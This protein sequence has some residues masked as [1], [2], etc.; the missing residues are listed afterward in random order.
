M[1]TDR[2][3]RNVAQAGGGW[4]T[5]RKYLSAYAAKHGAIALKL[6]GWEIDEAVYPTR[7]HR[8]VAVKKKGA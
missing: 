7:D 1:R 6:H 5:R 8:I 4:L 2:N 3:K